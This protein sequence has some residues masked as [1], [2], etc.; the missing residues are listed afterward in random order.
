VPIPTFWAKTVGMVY[1]NTERQVRAS[2]V[3]FM[4]IKLKKSVVLTKL[5]VKHR[6]KIIR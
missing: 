5:E 6:N 3:C 1:T 2:V 4:G